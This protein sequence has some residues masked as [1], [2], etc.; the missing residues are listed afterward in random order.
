TRHPSQIILRTFTHLAALYLLCHILRCRTKNHGTKPHSEE[1]E[2]VMASGRHFHLSR[3]PLR[4]APLSVVRT[5]PRRLLSIGHSY[6]VG[7]NRQLAHA[8]QRVARGRWE[9]QVAAPSYFHGSNDLRPVSF[10]PVAEESCPVTPIPA[11]LTR[12]VHLFAFNW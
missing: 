4:N 9:V 2:I 10:A 1:S 3:P 7:G 5:T 12:F 6:V 8:I 11:Y